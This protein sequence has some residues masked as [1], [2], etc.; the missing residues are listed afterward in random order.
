MYYIK[1]GLSPKFRIFAYLFAIS[2]MIAALGIGNAVQVNSV[3][4]VVSEEFQASEIIVG[5]IIAF[6][7]GLVILGGIKSIGNMTSK[8]VPLMSAIYVLGGLAII[9]IN[10]D[11]V[12]YVFSMIIDSAFTSTAATGGFAGDSVDGASIWCC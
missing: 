2:G 8:L 4:Q 11:Q 9:A 10:H 12:G 6:F 7:V 3:T 1:N 5:F